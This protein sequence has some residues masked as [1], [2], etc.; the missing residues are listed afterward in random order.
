MKRTI[1]TFLAAVALAVAG[2]STSAAISASAEN[3]AQDTS[4]AGGWWPHI[5]NT[6]VDAGGWWPH[7]Y[8]SS[9]EAGG[10]WP[11]STTTGDDI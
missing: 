11:N 1:A 8:N 10:W 3:P 4:V 2:F 7:F 6:S 5:S 9:V